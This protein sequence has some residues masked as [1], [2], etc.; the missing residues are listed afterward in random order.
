MDVSQLK[1]IK[2]LLLIAAIAV[3]AA[4]ARLV[5][6]GGAVM[7]YALL[8]VALVVIVTVYLRLDAIKN[9]NKSESTVPNKL[10]RDALTGVYTEQG[11]LY[12]GDRFLNEDGA[13]GVHGVL[14]AIIDNLDG[15]RQSNGG[16]FADTSLMTMAEKVCFIFRKTDIIGRFSDNGFFIFLKHADSG[17]Q[18]LSQTAALMA[19]LSVVTGDGEALE[20]YF[21]GGAIYKKDGKSCIELRDKAVIAL[22][23]AKTLGE[24]SYALYNEKLRIKN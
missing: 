20:N 3:A 22:E 15:I 1:F 17:A 11:A 18:L 9:F 24:N 14:V 13:E 16:D 8:G 4:I 23:H 7:V 19:E 5:F 21:I 12:L 10:E 2:M 6:N